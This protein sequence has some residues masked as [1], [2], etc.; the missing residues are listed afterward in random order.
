MN[1]YS[2][3]SSFSNTLRVTQSAALES[4][5][6]TSI[7]NAFLGKQGQDFKFSDLKPMK[8]SFLEASARGNKEGAEHDLKGVEGWLAQIA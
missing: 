6:S 1:Q 2:T 5:T 4:T 7:N 8:V 3:P